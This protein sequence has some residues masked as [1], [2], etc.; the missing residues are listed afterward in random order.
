MPLLGGYL[1][2][3]WWHTMLQPFSVICLLSWVIEN[4]TWNVYR[5][6]FVLLLLLCICNF[7][8]V[9]IVVINLIVPTQLQ[10]NNN[11]NK[12]TH[13]QQQQQQKINLHIFPFQ[14]S[15]T[16]IHWI[17]LCILLHCNIWLTSLTVEHQMSRKNIWTHNTLQLSTSLGH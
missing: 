7:V 10:V 11:N 3:T 15:T 16:H 4:W 13:K 5:L 12:I 6:I 17:T 9:V 2:P 1:W 14:F 8:V